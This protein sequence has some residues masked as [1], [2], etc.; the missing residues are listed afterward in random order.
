[1]SITSNHVGLHGNSADR[2]LGEQ[3]E[4]EFISIATLFGYE[5]WQV[6]KLR[7]PTLMWQGRRYIS[8]DVWILRR[9]NRQYACEVKHKSPNKHGSYGLE[10]YRANSLI[11][12][13]QF[14]TNQFGGVTSLYVIHDWSNNG[15][16][17]DKR[18]IIHHWRAQRLDELQKHIMGPYMGDTYYNG[19]VC[20]KPINYYAT[21]HF[22]A[23]LD[24]LI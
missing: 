15:N 7:G 21:R 9:D 3:W 8:P 10:E 22:A 18:N 17:N 24:F 12:L 19:I 13:Q 20:R 6:S 5:G 1:M 11:N 14:F 2:T 23:L 16:R 4:L